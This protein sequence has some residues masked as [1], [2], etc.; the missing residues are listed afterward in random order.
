MSVSI[1]TIT[2]V[3]F[4]PPN[5]PVY[6]PLQVGRID[7]PDYGY[8]GDDTGDN[9][10][11]KNAY[12]SEL[13]G[14]YWIW[15]NKADS[16][17]LGLCHYRRYFLNTDGELMKE[18]EY[19]AILSE[20]DVMISQSRLGEYDYKTI[21]GRSHDI[22]NLELTGEVI[23]ELC[24]DYSAT[25]EEVIA[26]NHCYVGNLFVAPKE[27]FCAYCEWLFSIF[28][29]MES[30][31][32]TS[33]YDDYHKRLF[34]F[35]SEQLLIVW[36]KHNH[37]TYY[38]TPFGLSQEKAET[39]ELKENLRK[40][41]KSKDI[42]GAYKRL[43]D[44]LDRRPDLIL[45][46]SDFN[47]E[48]RVIEH[49]LNV[50]R[51]ELESELPTLLAFSDDPDLLV[52][53]FNLLVQIVEHT[54]KGILDEKELQY[55]LD[56]Q[57]SYKAITY[58]MQ[59]MQSLS[60]NPLTDPIALLNQFAVLYANAN[61]PLKALSFLEEALRICDTDVITLQ[62]AASFFEQLGQHDAAAE[63]RQLAGRFAA[64]A[65]ISAPAAPETPD[66]KL[67]IVVFTG[68]RIPILNYISKQYINAFET[69]GHTV[70]AFDT[71][72]FEESV[73]MLFAWH[74]QRLDAIITF[75]N[76]GFRMN[77]KSGESL[78]D[79]WNVPCYNIVVDH[80]MYYAETLDNAPEHGIVAC[81]DRYHVDYCNRF[82]PT[83][84]KSIFLPTAGECLKPFAKLKP[85]GERSI[86]VLF[87][88]SYKYSSLVAS[89]YDDIEKYLEQEL[90]AHP[91]Q[92]FS[93]AVESFLAAGN[94]HWSTEKIKSLIESTRFVDMNVAAL[95]R[96]KIMET[97][98][99]GG[100]SV[101]VY[102][103]GWEETDIFR[104]PN[105]HYRGEISPEGG[106]ALMED[107][108]IVLNQLAWFKAGASE[109]IFEAMLQGAISLTDDSEYLRENFTDG[110][111]IQF[112][113]LKHLERL[114]E[115][116]HALLTDT[117]RSERI[118]QNAYEK[119]AANHTWESRA[120]ELL[121]LLL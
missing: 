100:I 65:S 35:L 28:F 61:D 9:I 88:G 107:A 112:F 21:Y 41:F 81:A 82:Y 91:S 37:L 57:V 97:L 96:K 120:K 25:F 70:Y 26:D 1:F 62:N 16:D 84:R 63:Y 73:K 13:T 38:E 34:G 10:S 113:S 99:T 118:R 104:H 55:L 5:D 79:L 3:P 102:G 80:P 40:D 77:M 56:A 78:W 47:Q 7:H 23:R 29:A 115:L 114:P 98:V 60:E 53:H 74:E 121:Q 59:N 18:S 116:A 92:L 44:T 72:Y 68:W 49:I 45:D 46:M 89:Q 105:F 52:K 106:I 48:L 20:Y 71:Q 12:Y 117:T 103:N 64:H 111:D 94:I 32:D 93:D 22:R 4:T 17:Y 33:G 69:L 24:P 36:I 66:R 15:K 83:V 11:D 75:N 54:E 90:M 108:K 76:V 86:D 8:L 67:S 110:E 19:E 85:F 101:T 119:A 50:C 95:F 14:L 6:I 2:H 31:I 109:R 42:L 51:I 30:R 27:L 58:I 39:I 87:I 43:C